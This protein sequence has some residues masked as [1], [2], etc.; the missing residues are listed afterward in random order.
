MPGGTMLFSKNQIYNLP[1][2]PAYFSK[3]K[4]AVYGI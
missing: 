4:N 3:A 2:W 1:K